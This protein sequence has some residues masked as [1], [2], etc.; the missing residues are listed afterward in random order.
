MA[1]GFFFTISATEWCQVILAVGLVWAAELFNTSVEGL[2]DLLEP[3]KRHLAGRIK[4]IAAGGV[5]MAALC[6]AAVGALVFLKY[7]MV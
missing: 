1:A 7:L 4:D 2:V 6:A 5:L 3:G